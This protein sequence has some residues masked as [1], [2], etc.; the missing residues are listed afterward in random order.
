MLGKFYIKYFVTVGSSLGL[1]VISC[2]SFS[3]PAK[4]AL[5]CKGGTINYFSNGSAA[6]CTIKN[7][8]NITT[9]SLV[10]S[11]K[12]DYSISFDEKANFKSCVISNSVII[13]RNNDVETCPEKSRIYVSS[14]ND[15]SLSVRCLH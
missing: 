8:V 2:L 11:C 6:S 10:F 14:L 13:R 15:G 3:L 4:A 7:N 12:Q 9:G 5:P 1:F